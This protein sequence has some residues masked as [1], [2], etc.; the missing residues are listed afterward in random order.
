VTSEA[1]D[2]FSAMMGNRHGMIRYRCYGIFLRLTGVLPRLRLAT[3]LSTSRP[4][5]IRD[6]APAKVLSSRRPKTI[7]EWPPIDHED[8]VWL[9]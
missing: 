4:T 3:V 8:A 2:V 5:G 9:R 1:T 6:W 7:D